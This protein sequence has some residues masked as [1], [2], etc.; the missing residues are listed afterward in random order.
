MLYRHIQIAGKDE[1]L[2]TQ[3]PTLKYSVAIERRRTGEPS[4]LATYELG[5]F[6]PQFPSAHR[7]RPL[8]HRWARFYWESNNDFLSWWW[9]SLT[10]GFVGRQRWPRQMA[11]SVG[12][13]CVQVT[14]IGVIIA[15][16]VEEILLTKDEQY[17][18]SNMDGLTEKTIDTGSCFTLYSDLSSTMA[19]SPYAHVQPGL[20]SW[21]ELAVA[22]DEGKV[23]NAGCSTGVQ[24]TRGRACTV[25]YDVRSV[26][27]V[28]RAAQRCTTLLRALKAFH[29]WARF[30]PAGYDKDDDKRQCALSC[31]TCEQCAQETHI[32]VTTALGDEEYNWTKG[33]YFSNGRAYHTNNHFSV[34]LDPLHPH[35]HATNMHRRFGL[36]SWTELTLTCDNGGVDEV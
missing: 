3:I 33:G 6:L 23:D 4:I 35:S 22:H 11:R 2:E 13:A 16:C 28:L 34:A 12:E 7:A 1:F 14:L 18:T 32:L 26:G 5:P 8:L 29:R 9:C 25:V 36:T 24:T 10:C 17:F 31:T 27:Q 21:S 19:D 20:R 30:Y 15:Q